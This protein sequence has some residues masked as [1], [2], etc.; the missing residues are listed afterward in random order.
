M[1]FTD[2]MVRTLVN[3][4]ITMFRETSCEEKRAKARAARDEMFPQSKSVKP[5]ESKVRFG[6]ASF[7]GYQAGIGCPSIR[8][9]PA[10]IRSFWDR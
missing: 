3:R 1:I 7:D 2:G 5:K 6:E 4:L 10:I 9:L 8:A